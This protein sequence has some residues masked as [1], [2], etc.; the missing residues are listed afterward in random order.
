MIGNMNLRRNILL[1]AYKL[2]DLLTMTCAFLLAAWISYHQMG[3][4]SFVEF[5]EMRIKD[6]PTFCCF[7]AFSSSGI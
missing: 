7:S 5:M 4:I 6:S 3:R 1:K 2:F